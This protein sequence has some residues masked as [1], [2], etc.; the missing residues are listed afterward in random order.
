MFL[1]CAQPTVLIHKIIYFNF[2][3]FLGI[4]AWQICVN[5][6]M[7]YDPPE[8]VEIE[9]I[10]Q[11]AQHLNFSSSQPLFELSQFTELAISPAK[12][13]GGC[14]MTSASSYSSNSTMSSTR[15]N[16]PNSCDGH[17]D[18]TSDDMSSLTE[19]SVDSSHTSTYQS[20]IPEDSDEELP[21]V[22]DLP[23]RPNLQVR[24]D[25]PVRPVLRLRMNEGRLAL[26][27]QFN[28]PVNE[29][30]GVRMHK[31]YCKQSSAYVGNPYLA[32]KRRLST[33]S[34]LYANPNDMPLDLST[35]RSANNRLT[36]NVQ[37]NMLISTENST[38]ICN[39]RSHESN[40]VSDSQYVCE[41]CN[42]TPMDLSTE[43]T[44][45]NRLGEGSDST[46]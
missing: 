9:S 22:P 3:H 10:P 19:P 7:G 6:A 35:N 29:R 12:H 5:E 18:V 23:V 2:R 38:R 33:D 14:D 21:V 16:A 15:S 30:N 44:T 1:Y 25:L 11:F 20:D 42:A 4:I 36:S 24:P 41:E 46:K 45:D 13:C 31:D 8:F 34:D 40:P 43:S 17:S 39:H 26:P 27:C 37:W 28:C 32:R